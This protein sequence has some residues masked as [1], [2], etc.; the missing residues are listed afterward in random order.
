MQANNATDSHDNSVREEYVSTGIL[1]IAM[2][3]LASLPWVVR[4]VPLLDYPNVLAE[5]H[6]VGKLLQD[7]SRYHA[8]WKVTWTPTP[9]SLV[10]ALLGWLSQG[11]P[12]ETAGKGVLTCYLLGFPCGLLV[13]NKLA[14][15]QTAAPLGLL[16]TL[17]WFFF[18]GFVG[19]LVSL[20]LAFMAIGLLAV[21]AKQRRLR[22]L[23]AFAAL[24]LACYFTHLMGYLVLLITVICFSLFS[25]LR[26]RK[27]I[28]TTGPLIAQILPL[29]CLTLYILARVDDQD[30]DFWL[31]DSALSKGFSIVKPFL[32]LPRLSPAY[33]L[34][35]TSVVN[36]LLLL[37]LIGTVIG[38]GRRVVWSYQAAAGLLLVIAGLV[39]PFT[40][41]GGLLRPDERLVFPGVLLV[42]SAMPLAISPV[43]LR[44]WVAIGLLALSILAW[45]QFARVQ[46]SF[47]YID[48]VVS[49]RIEQDQ[50]ILVLAVR[51]SPA[52]NACN[53]VW[54][55]LGSVSTFPVLRLPF[56]SAIRSDEAIELPLFETGLVRPREFPTA[57]APHWVEVI[58]LF[59]AADA[60]QHDRIQERRVASETTVVAFGCPGDLA[61]LEAVLNPEL[62]AP[63]MEV[64]VPYMR[65][66]ET[67]QRVPLLRDE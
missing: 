32:F 33:E 64:N 49:E 45:Y 66:Y 52:Y 57:T 25:Y 15:Q 36:G 9:N 60:R 27:H 30:I 61:A 2:A 56:Y 62:H 42:L 34:G 39:S 3:T 37:A 14:P 5:G 22:M 63:S 31:Y 18:Q 35:Y 23:A 29:I 1:L 21:W 44:L 48:Q 7:D 46:S 4:F 24:S 40:W 59:S 43:R 53:H 65:I 38:Y 12:V 26:R 50:N 41:F 6:V 58:E 55:N 54:G 28:T 10:P 11:M 13:L 16:W 17:N 67:S 19:Y 8:L 51:R 20:V 47:E